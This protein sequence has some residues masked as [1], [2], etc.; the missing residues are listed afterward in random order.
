MLNKSFYRS[1]RFFSQKTHS[2]KFKKPTKQKTTVLDSPHFL[3]IMKSG[4]PV[5]P[6]NKQPRVYI[7]EEQMDALQKNH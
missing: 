2:L 1:C 4:K 5:D 6:K 7:S 3:A